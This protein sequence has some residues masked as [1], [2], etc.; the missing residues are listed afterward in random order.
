MDKKLDIDMILLYAN[1]RAQDIVFKEDFDSM[2][3]QYPRLKVTHVLCES[4]PGF[5]YIVGLI[6]AQ[7][8]KKEVPDYTQRK[9]YIC[10]PPGMVE[11]MKRI[12]TD[13]LALPKESIVT[14]N[15]Q[16]Y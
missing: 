6:N 13:E 4:E 10:G 9:F 12:L 3:R 15:F 5:N 16:G 2:Y 7:V 14:E 1:R 8:I 11:A